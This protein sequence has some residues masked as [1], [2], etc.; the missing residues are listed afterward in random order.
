MQIDKQHRTEYSC[1]LNKR[2]YE[3]YVRHEVVIGI[4][5]LQ[6]VT[7]TRCCY[8]LDFMCCKQH[9]GHSSNKTDG[10]QILAM[11]EDILT[12][13][14]KP[15]RCFRPATNPVLL[16][17]REIGRVLTGD[18]I[19]RFTNLEGEK[20]HRRD[21]FNTTTFSGDDFRILTVTAFLGA[22]CDFR[23]VEDGDLMTNLWGLCDGL[24]LP[25][26]GD[27]VL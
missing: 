24:V 11:E 6:S 20:E 8:S 7:R 9:F 3:S 21:F 27:L 1:R 2:S 16:L 10:V 12:G 14:L 18:A 23:D 17:R 5:I 19:I 15:E 26:T 4:E 13:V 25:I 22:N